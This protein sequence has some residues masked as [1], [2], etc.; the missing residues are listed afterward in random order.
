MPWTTQRRGTDNPETEANHNQRY[1]NGT[2][3]QV[4]HRIEDERKPQLSRT[5]G[6]VVKVDDSGVYAQ[7]DFYPQSKEDGQPIWRCYLASQVSRTTVRNPNNQD[8]SP[9][10]PPHWRWEVGQKRYPGAYFK[11]E[12]LT[13]THMG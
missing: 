2:L 7:M 8:N 1:A 10:I 6:T 11:T 5:Y 12:N 9:W 4:G 3:I 13:G